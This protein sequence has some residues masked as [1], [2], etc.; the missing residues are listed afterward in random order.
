MPNLTFPI[1]NVSTGPHNLLTYSNTVTNNMFS[2]FLLLSI[3]LILFINLK[4]RGFQTEK[5]LVSAAFST[6]LVSY[7]MIII[8]DFISPE[9]A[10]IMTMITAVSVLLLYKTGS[11]GES[12]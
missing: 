2:I 1:P 6:T 10:V 9:I 12:Y 8:P 7:I 4:T 5:A 3:F 11:G